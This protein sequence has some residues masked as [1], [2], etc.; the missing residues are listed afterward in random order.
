MELPDELLTVAEFAVG[1]AGFSAI[2]GAFSRFVSSLSLLGGRRPF[3]WQR[4]CCPS[5]LSSDPTDGTPGAQ[6]GPV[7]AI[8]RSIRLGLLMGLLLAGTHP[9]RAQLGEVDFA[10]KLVRAHFVEGLPYAEARDL[11]AAGVDRLVEMLRN[12]AEAEHHDN[13]VMALGISR[14][15]QAY[16]ALVGFQDAEVEGEVDAA[17]YRARRAVPLAM[18]HLASS[19]PRALQFLLEAARREAPEAAPRWRYRYL[20][21]QKLAGILRRAAITGMAMSGQPEAVAALR[22]L[23]EHT[24]LDPRASYEL[25]SHLHEAER[26]CDRVMREGLDRVFGEERTR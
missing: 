4:H 25:R 22:N 26:L 8:S 18:G 9:A 24:R 3:P 6:Y 23:R 10:E 20:R 5:L 16:G 15:P 17:E 19:D 13:I 12:P 14:A 2:V 21:E 1:I 11:T 7:E